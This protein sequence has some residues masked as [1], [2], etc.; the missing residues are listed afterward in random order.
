MKH[1]KYLKDFQPR[2]EPV[3][4]QKPATC[5]V[6]KLV[7]RLAKNQDGKCYWC[8]RPGLKLTFDHIVPAS[9]GGVYSISNGVAACKPCN[10]R[11]G[12]MDFDK[13]KRIN[14]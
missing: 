8:K 10:C 2:Q 4:R 7:N 9:K 13:F 1:F 6:R 5:V 14:P 11:R 12:S 3:D